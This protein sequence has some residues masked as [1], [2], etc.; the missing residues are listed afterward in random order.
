MSWKMVAAYT[1][2]ELKRKEKLFALAI[3]N[4]LFLILNQMNINDFLLL[5][6]F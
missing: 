6:M 4:L 2:E 1:L 3:S 5:K